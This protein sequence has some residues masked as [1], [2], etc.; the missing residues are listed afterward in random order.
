VNE[1]SRL[2]SSLSPSFSDG[3]ALHP[4]LRG[5]LSNLTLSADGAPDLAS[6]NRFVSAVDLGY[7]E[8]AET[9]FD[10]AHGTRGWSAFENLFQMSPI[11]LM[12]QDYTQA[13]IWM[14]SLRD[15]GICDIADFL[16]GD[17]ETIRAVVPKIKVVAANPAAIEA[18]GIPLSQ[19]KGPIDP[20]IV[21]EGSV[22]GWTSQF[23]AVWNRIPVSRVAFKAA[24]RA[25]KEYDAESILSAP[26]LNGEPDFSRAV[27]TIIDVTNHRNEERRMLELME[28]K[29]SFLASVSHEIRTPLTAIVGFAQLLGDEE[30]GL[31]EDDRRLMVSSIGQQ[32]QEVANLIDDLL[33]V[34]RNEMAEV[35]ILET[36]VNVLEQL[37]QTLDAGGSFTSEVIIECKTESPE[38]I[39]D[40]GRIRQILRNLLTNAERYGGPEVRV[41]LAGK[42]GRV[43]VS[44]IDNGSGIP[45]GD[46]ERV[47][48]AYQ[49][50]H[51]V[52][53]QPES[54]GIGLAISRQLAERMGGTL[55]YRYEDN[56]SIFSLTLRAATS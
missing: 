56:H 19:F 37:E 18:V 27:L 22:P 51:V 20:G 12:E 41:T 49:R 54:V 16:D 38:A 14:D 5:L 8:I 23:S 10:P 45:A 30:D 1:S 52:G 33:V 17:V 3:G 32:A 9:G 2:L 6:W 55:D 29:N 15:E 21:N 7:R 11:P 25:G 34:A 43:V 46:W 26:V 36:N 44:V 47:F 35:Y 53:D 31:G 28:A 24:T 48:E 13:E 50:A 4:H 39:G 40:P 42:D